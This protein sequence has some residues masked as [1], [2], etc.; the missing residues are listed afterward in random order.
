[1][2]KRAKMSSVNQNQDL[3][4]PARSAGGYAISTCCRGTPKVYHLRSVESVPPLTESI[5]FILSVKRK[6]KGNGKPVKDGTEND[7]I[8]TFSGWVV[9][10]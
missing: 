1:M 8:P 3:T 2:K 9:R 6:D 4:T 7:F 10:A 5:I